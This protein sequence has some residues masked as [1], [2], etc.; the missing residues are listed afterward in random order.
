VKY[1]DL[2]KTSNQESGSAM[3]YLFIFSLAL[4]L[5]NSA[6]PQDTLTVNQAVQRVLERHPAI[7]QGNESVRAAEARVLQSASSSYP[8]VTTEA[9]YAFLGPIAKL[10][11]PGLGEFKLY[12]ADNY[13]VHVGG[14]YTVYDFGRIDA[15]VNVTRS[16]VQSGRDGVELTKNNLAYQT[17]RVFYSIL[18]L[19]KSIQVQNEQIEALQQHMLSTQ[20]RVNAG[21]ATSFDVLTTQVRVAAAQSQKIDLENALQKQRAVLGQ[22]L[23]LAPGVQVQIRGDFEQSTPPATNESLLQAASQQRPEIKLAQDAEHSAELQ[24]ELASLGNKPS[25]K[26]N[27]AY[28]LKNGYIPNLDVLRGN[29]VAG[30]KAEVPLFDGWRTDHQQEEAQATM[31]AE[32]AHRRDIERQVSSDVEQATADY[33]TAVSKISI[34]DLQVQQAKEAVSIARSRYDTGTVTNLDLLDAQ[35]AESAARL[36]NLQALYRL[37]MSKFEVQ[38]AIGAKPWE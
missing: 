27:L 19:D 7:V 6:Y 16:R 20:R 15:A 18:F 10:A 31:L 4:F 17:I 14:R 38:R 36:G 1:F 37:V 34:S 9:S 33:Q 22:L 11:F 3:R 12:P 25:L 2:Y 32:Q 28:G 23:G 24:R 29:W 21:T 35:A 26:V 30:V 5:F 8:D 13:D